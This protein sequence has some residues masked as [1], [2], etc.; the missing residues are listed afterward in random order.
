[1]R[2]FLILIVFA[3]PASVFAQE[4]PTVQE[5]ALKSPAAGRINNE[6]WCGTGNVCG[7]DTDEQGRDGAWVSTN[8]HVAT[9]QVQPPD[10]MS[11]TIMVGNAARQFTGYNKFAAYSDRYQT[12]WA[13]VFVPGLTAA[14]GI[15]PVKLSKNGPVGKNFQT[16]GSPQC[17]WPLKSSDLV[18]Q[19]MIQD[20]RVYRWSPVAI[21][22]Q[23]GSAVRNTSSGHMELL[24]TWQ[25]GR[26]GAGQPT[27]LIYEQKRNKTVE[28]PLRVEGLIEL[29]TQDR[30]CENGYFESPATANLL[31]ARTVQELPVWVEE[32]EEPEEP[33]EPN[34]ELTDVEMEAAIHI[35]ALGF[36]L[37][38]VDDLLTGLML[39]KETAKPNAFLLNDVSQKQTDWSGL[40]AL[41][42]TIPIPSTQEASRLKQAYETVSKELATTKNLETGRVMVGKAVKNAQ[43]GT[44]WNPFLQAIGNYLIENTPTTP[45]EYSEAILAVARG[46]SSA[47]NDSVPL[48]APSIS[49]NLAPPTWTPPFI[50][51]IRLEESV[52]LRVDNRV[53]T[54]RCIGT[55]CV[56]EWVKQ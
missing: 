52:G 27:K 36:D 37:K 1:M 47:A 8:A 18:L 3:L 12:D 55:E 42:K 31:M 5:L 50:P 16:T 45:K 48:N 15:K 24:L 6:N 21:G 23:S 41:V 35:K 38:A 13:F 14:S 20:G 30:K 53:L 4:M 49:V 54:K 29:A 39:G 44:A 7:Y 33:E 34:D 26:F 2:A 56:Y 51:A 19:D 22:G 28:G 11:F 46:L 40:T 17:V 25:W 43:L 32:N 10:R 9:T